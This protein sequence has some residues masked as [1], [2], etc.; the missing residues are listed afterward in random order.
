M[1]S[2]R[3]QLSGRPTLAAVTPAISPTFIHG[4]PRT[5]TYDLV[6]THKPHKKGTDKDLPLM[7]MRS[8]FTIKMELINMKDGVTTPM[9]LSAAKLFY[10]EKHYMADSDQHHISAVYD[11]QDIHEEAN[12]KIEH[13]Q[14]HVAVDQLVDEDNN[15]FEI[16]QKLTKDGLPIYVFEDSDAEWTVKDEGGR[17]EQ[18]LEGTR[19]AREADREIKLD[20][21]SRK[22]QLERNI[23]RKRIG[24]SESWGEDDPDDETVEAKCL[25]VHGKCSEGSQECGG[26]CDDG[27]TGRYCDTPVATGEQLNSMRRGRGSADY[28]DGVYRPERITEGSGS[29]SHDSWAGS[30]VSSS[31]ESHRV[32]KIDDTDDW[33]H[34]VNTNFGTNAANN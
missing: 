10:S 30:S 11:L 2:T 5:I 25:C 1:Y 34:P 21:G 22:S 7:E 23:E 33:G 6:F 29:S 19:L 24:K 31:S 4:R 32:Q 3:H 18:A 27:Y 14:L 12:T 28:K 20:I 26:S 9:S 16:T 13:A 17:V 15:Q 8:L